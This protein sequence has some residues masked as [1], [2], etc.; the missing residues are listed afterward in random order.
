MIY[1]LMVLMVQ[2]VETETMQILGTG[3]INNKGFTLI[4][5]MVVLVIIGIASSYVILNT[6]II[7][8]MKASENPIEENFFLLTEESI[9]RGSTIHWFASKKQDR[10]YVH[11]SID[12]SLE[13][14]DIDGFTF[15]D[16]FDENT[17]ITINASN[18]H[19]YPIDNDM[20]ETPLISFYPSGEN[21]GA[22]ISI[23]SKENFFKIIVS[24]NGFIK[25]E[26]DTE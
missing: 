10:F 20:S 14:I 1:L 9:L 13:N 18:G 25:K 12:N 15:I 16:N 6:S 26:I 22:I 17:M 24:Q 8:F 11:N 2:S 19:S 4:E 23:E 21:S 7:D 5:L 3:R